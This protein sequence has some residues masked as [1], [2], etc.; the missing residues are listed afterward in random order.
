[1]TSWFI[2]SDQNG[3]ELSRH[4]TLLRAVEAQGA[5]DQCSTITSTGEPIDPQDIEIAAEVLRTTQERRGFEL[6]NYFHGMRLGTYATRAE[7]EAA[8]AE[9][10][11]L[12][13]ANR[14]N[15]GVEVAR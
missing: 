10:V 1:V 15:C 9:Q 11:E 6:R 2:L 8:L 4:R 5:L 13:P 3:A 14:I 12:N 7:A